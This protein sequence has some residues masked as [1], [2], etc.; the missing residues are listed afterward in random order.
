MNE[1]PRWRIIEIDT[2]NDD[3]VVKSSGPLDHLTFK[4]QNEE[5][6]VEDMFQTEL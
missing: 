4:D 6:K 1:K 3:I 5:T 2:C